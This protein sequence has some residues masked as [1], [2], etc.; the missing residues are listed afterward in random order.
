MHGSALG[1]FS[2]RNF[3]N[4]MLVHK[5]IVKTLVSQN[6]RL[7]EENEKFV[8]ENVMKMEAT[9]REVKDLKTL[10]L[11]DNSVHNANFTSY[12]NTLVAHYDTEAHMVDEI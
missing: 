9:F 1:E 5:A 3:Q 10:I 4:M 11:N 2:G 12:I 8:K 6:K 7:L